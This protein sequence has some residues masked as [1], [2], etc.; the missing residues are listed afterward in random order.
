MPF[1]EKHQI[2]ST[3]TCK[4]CIVEKREATM[5]KK[6]GV[7][8]ALYSKDIKE[9]KNATCLEKYGVSHSF[10][11]EEIKQ[12]CKESML[13]KYG[14][15]FSL[16]VPTVRDKG[17]KTMLEKYGVE[18]AIQNNEIKQKRIE[19]NIERFGVENALQNSNILQKRRETNIERYGVEEVLKMPEIQNKIK[20]IMIET[21]GVTNPLQC[22]EIKD[23][24]DKTCEE[25]YGD[26]DIMKN[27]N[28]FEKVVKNSFKKKEYI[29]PSG[30]VITYQGYEDVALNELLKTFNET[31]ITN[32]VK[33]M[34]K[35][36]YQ[37]ND[38]K[39]RYYPDIYIPTQKRIIEIKSPYTY[40]KQLEQNECKKAQTIQDGYTFEFW[41]CNKKEIIEKK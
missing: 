5:L 40:N 8:S 38:K 7:K 9:K 36:I 41:I 23:R 17:N 6:Y 37:F 12:K 32:D 24:K 10:A 20:T 1:C 21:Y 3:H 16:S 14:A 22:I 28:I 11:N 4:K 30:K 39:H 31:E 34:P 26:K 27:A 33:L 18:H 19:T 2:E 29:L 15:E 25:R 35:I 13:K